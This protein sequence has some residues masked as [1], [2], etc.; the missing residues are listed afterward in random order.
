MDT[1]VVLFADPFNAMEPFNS[2]L[3]I[4]SGGTIPKEYPEPEELFREEL[5]T[6]FFYV[7]AN[8]KMVE[9][10]THVILELS[11]REENV[12]FGD[13]AAFNVV[14]W[15]WQWRGGGGRNGGGEDVHF[16][17][18]HPTRYPTGGVFFEHHDEVYGVGKGV[19]P[20]LVH[21]NFIIGRGK[22][23]E[24]FKRHGLWMRDRVGEKEWGEVM[25]GGWGREYVKILGVKGAYRTFEQTTPTS[26]PGVDAD[27][28]YYLPFVFAPVEVYL[29][30]HPHPSQRRAIL[31]MSCS[32]ET[33]TWFRVHTLP[34]MIDYALKTGSD[35]VVVNR[36]VEC[37]DWANVKMTREILGA[38]KSL[39][40]VDDDHDIK[41]HD[42]AKLLKVRL[43][44][45]AMDAGWDRVLYLDDTVLISRSSDDIFDVVKVGVLGAT[46]ETHKGD[47]KASVRVLCLAYP[48]GG[49]GGRIY[50]DEGL[51]DDVEGRGVTFNSGV[52]VMDRDKH[53]EGLREHMGEFVDSVVVKRD[54][55]YINAVAI[56]EDWAV[57]DLGFSWNY[58]GSF[59][60]LDEGGGVVGLE[61][62][63]LGNAKFVHVTT[64]VYA[65][66]KAEF[67]G[68]FEERNK[69]IERL[70]EIMT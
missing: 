44:I 38:D 20:I 27:D 40:V 53:L 5:C 29:N 28:D 66:L 37:E 45:D 10:M 50:V 23:E 70:N 36:V 48:C 42:C 12:Q 13:Q 49:R 1:D 21:N 69:V 30:P 32:S 25:G 64:G 11:T 63:G 35:V 22:K 55:G 24:R 46:R 57:Q 7:K 4:Q 34:R 41:F 67:R 58:L 31:T 9:F 52:L 65:N 8:G 54:Q 26:T 33:R 14:L 15:E 17:V 43:W 19:P 47:A 16:M 18:L 56:M 6:G 61:N 3:Y 51:R 59:L 62:G 68:S 39:S 60:V 2:D